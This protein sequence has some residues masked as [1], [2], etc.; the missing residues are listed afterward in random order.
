MMYFVTDSTKRLKIAVIVFIPAILKRYNVMHYI[1]RP[2]AAC[3]HRVLPQVHSS[4]IGPTAVVSSLVSRQT[5]VG[6]DRLMVEAIVT[7]LGVFA[8]PLFC[9]HSRGSFRHLINLVH[10]SLFCSVGYRWSFMG[11][12]PHTCTLPNSRHVWVK[13]VASFYVFF[14]APFAK[15]PRYS[16]PGKIDFIN[17]QLSTFRTKANR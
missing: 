10:K 17:M 3:A 14:P 2:A 5:L 13:V 6:P 8:A 16:T 11:L 12:P 9:T 15:H 7:L 4:K 1:S